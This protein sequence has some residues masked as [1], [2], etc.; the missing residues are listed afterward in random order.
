MKNLFSLL[1][2]LNR[3]LFSAIL[4]FFDKVG[5]EEENNVSHSYLSYLLG[6]LLF[7]DRI[8]GEEEEGGRQKER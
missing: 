1:P 5:N 3:R 7:Y 6:P 2:E 4:D 8:D